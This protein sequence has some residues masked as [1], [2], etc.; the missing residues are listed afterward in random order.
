MPW[1]NAEANVI[2]ASTASHRHAW[3]IAGIYKT[4]DAR[5][6]RLHTNF[7]H[8]RDA[9]WWCCC[10]PEREEVQAAL[11]QWDGEAFETWPMPAAASSPDAPA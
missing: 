6:V 1:S 11:M 2:C 7:P 9:V 8:H 5:F 4:R 3:D 10:K